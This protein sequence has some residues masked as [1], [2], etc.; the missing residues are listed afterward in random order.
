M[1]IY[2]NKSQQIQIMNNGTE[3]NQQIYLLKV[4]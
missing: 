2:K 4:T 1:H 3:N